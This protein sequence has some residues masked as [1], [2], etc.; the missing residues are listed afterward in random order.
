MHRTLFVGRLSSFRR[1]ITKFKIHNLDSG[2]KAEILSGSCLS[3][4]LSAFRLAANEVGGLDVDDSE[5]IGIGVIIEGDTIK[6]EVKDEEGD[7][8]APLLP[9]VIDEGVEEVV[10]VVGGEATLEETFFAEE[11]EG[12]LRKFRSG[13]AVDIISLIGCCDS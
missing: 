4:N 11:R 9:R 12:L 10:V 7:S 6:V 8:K 2:N 1:A 5:E 3:G 13:V